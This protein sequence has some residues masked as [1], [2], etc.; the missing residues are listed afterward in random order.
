MFHPIWDKNNFY[1]ITDPHK[2]KRGEA[3]YCCGNS[4]FVRMR[5]FKR[6]LP[7]AYIPLMKIKRTVPA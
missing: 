2:S 1:F 4:P 5:A 6:P 3:Y 7:G